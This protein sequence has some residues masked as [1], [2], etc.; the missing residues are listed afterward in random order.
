MSAQGMRRCLIDLD[1]AGARRLWGELFPQMPQPVDDGDIVT[2]LH[3]ARTASGSVP[4]RARAYSHAWLC[5]RHLPSQMPDGLKPR[6]E[7][8]HPRMVGAV[9]I[10]VK[11]KWPAVSKAIGGAMRGA[12]LDCYANGDEHPSIV[13]PRM[14]AARRKEQIALGTKAKW[15]TLVPVGE[16]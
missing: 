2:T 3:L 1:V 12:V 6:A 15:D 7:R 5:E 16:P 13:R 4:F 11:S 9:G 8:L 14:L 10:A